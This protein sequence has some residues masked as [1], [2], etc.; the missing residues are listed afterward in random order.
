MLRLTPSLAVLL[1]LACGAPSAPTEPLA[2][3]APRVDPAIELADRLPS[4][5]DRCVVVRPRRLS[6][7]QRA[8]VTRF[9]WADP[10][11]FQDGL[12]VE[13][14]A[15]ASVRLPGGQ[16]ARRTLYRFTRGGTPPRD[17]VG[18]GIDQGD[19]CPGPGCGNRSA[20]W[21][22]E[23]TLAVTRYRWPERGQQPMRS[24]F[25][26]PSCVAMARTHPEAFEVA[27]SR[28]LR[29]SR[30][31]SPQW[32]LRSL[33]GLGGMRLRVER[34]FSN[35][36]DARRF[37]QALGLGYDAAGSLSSL[38]PSEQ[39]I[40]RDVH[41]VRVS[42][43]FSWDALELAQEDQ[44]LRREA[45]RR[46]RHRQSPS[47]VGSVDVTRLDRVRGEMVLHRAQLDR[48]ATGQR[49][50]HARAY[51]QL[52]DRAL[53][54][55]PNTPELVRERVTLALHDLDEPETAVP[56]VDRMLESGAAEPESWRLLRRD[57]LCRRG[58]APFVE[59][60]VDDSLAGAAEAEAAAA[61]IRG[62]SAG[63]MQYESAERAWIL[64]RTL[65]SGGT[66]PL[67]DVASNP[68]L[69]FASLFSTVAVLLSRR[70]SA[71]PQVLF[72]LRVSDRA[73]GFGPIG[74]GAEAI[75]FEL[76]PDTYFVGASADGI[77]SFQRL[78]RAVTEQVGDARVTVRV[79]FRDQAGQRTAQATLEGDAHA[80][81]FTLRSASLP[82]ARQRWP[83]VRRYVAQP[84]ATLA[85]TLFPPPEIRI[86]ADSAELAEQLRRV[87]VDDCTTSGMTVR[88]LADHDLD[89]LMNALFEAGLRG[90]QGRPPP[91][92]HAPL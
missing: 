50:T 5:F 85:P 18:L 10:R 29:R 73:L 66:G 23:H 53:A 7:R 37:E 58:G 90:A 15:T 77:S 1:A 38:P 24:G 26:S 70:A 8:L 59:A 35:E 56:L 54:V 78:T 61:A 27:V 30:L 64:Q 3:P 14:F 28:S 13:A 31:P 79:E 47:P 9:S 4:G 49:S 65:F 42:D 74:D 22:D 69:P 88:C 63:G 40:D 46:G 76:G 44:R 55:H 57:V 51:A 68:R 67:S 81:D 89:R 32:T 39:E 84:L 87:S 45:R 48:A 60:L 41:R 12:G 86:R 72:G 16:L 71:A 52:L 6:A 2:R 83:H 82:L 75:R 11:A 21:L 25:W 43:R 91:E 33:R 36:E 92:R 34:V 20:E 17:R 19:A 62:L 80:D